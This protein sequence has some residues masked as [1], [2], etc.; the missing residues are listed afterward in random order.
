M[1]DELVDIF[2]ENYKCVG[3]ELKSEARKSGHWVHSFH[4]WIV[5]NDEKGG[6]LQF[7]KRGAD[8]DLFPNYLDI[9][10]AGHY[11]S[12]EKIE[13]GVREI[14]EEIGLKVKYEDL[15]SL[16]IKFDLAKIGSIINRQFCHVFLLESKFRANEYQL[17]LDEV[18]G[19]VEISINEGL[20]LF[21]G[22]IDAAHAVGVE[23]DVQSKKWKPVSFKVTKDGFIPRVDQYYYKMFILVKRYLDG[24]K[25]LVI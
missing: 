12:G 3:N 8:K 19:M 24:E 2:D 14:Q 20:D 7:Q 4:C 11:R 16:G 1:A 22:K 23:Y 9:T 5:R 25:H 13:E 18:E 15:I 17:D 21:S 10:A 6:Y